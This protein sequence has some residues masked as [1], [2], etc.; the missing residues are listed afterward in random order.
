[1]N[2]SRKEIE[3]W[4]HSLELQ[5]KERTLL[6]HEGRY[7]TNIFLFKIKNTKTQFENA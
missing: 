1:M 3:N 6:N 4:H 5:W 2:F 7:S